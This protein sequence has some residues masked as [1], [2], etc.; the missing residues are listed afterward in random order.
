MPSQFKGTSV[1]F[2]SIQ[3]FGLTTGARITVDVQFVGED[4]LTHATT[5]HELEL[6]AD[7]KV[8]DA[9][10]ELHTALRAFVE[11]LHYTDAN[12]SLGAGTEGVKPRGIVE[13]VRGFSDEPDESTSQ[14]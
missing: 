2:R 9:A 1:H 5:R 4:G 6:S 8:A 13:S 14:G 12:S 10:R 11:G 7:P 3:I